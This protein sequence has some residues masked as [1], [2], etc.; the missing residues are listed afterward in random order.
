MS[1]IAQSFKEITDWKESKITEFTE[2]GF[3][4]EYLIGEMEK[5]R[6]RFEQEINAFYA[7]AGGMG[8]IEYDYKQSKI[9]D[10]HRENMSAI[11]IEN[12]EFFDKIEEAY[13]VKL[14]E[15]VDSVGQSLFDTDTDTALSDFLEKSGM[16]SDA[17]YDLTEAAFKSGVTV[18]QLTGYFGQFG[19]SLTEGL[20]AIQGLGEYTSPYEK[21]MDT[22][23]IQDAAKYFETFYASMFTPFE[24][25]LATVDNEAQ[26]LVKSLQGLAAEYPIFADYITD[27]SGFID[28]MADIQ[29][30]QLA[31]DQMSM[32]GQAQAQAMGLDSEYELMRLESTYGVN[33][34]ST[35][36]QQDILS[37]L[38]TASF[39][40]FLQLSTDLNIPMQTLIND[41]LSLA[42]I[43]NET[44]DEF[45]GLADNIRDYTGK[46]SLSGKSYL[47][48]DLK[49]TLARAEF[50]ELAALA[51]STDKETAAAAMAELPAAADTLLDLSRQSNTSMLAYNT[52]MSL[53]LSSLK[54]AEEHAEDY[55][56]TGDDA[57][58]EAEEQTKH[59]K[60]LSHLVGINGSIQDIDS[61]IKN[62]WDHPDVQSFISDFD[63][64]FGPDKLGTLNT[65]VGDLRKTV[66]DY[67][68]SL[69][70]SF[71]KGIELSPSA[72]T[73][74]T[75]GVELSLENNTYNALMAGIG[76]NQESLNALNQLVYIEKYGNEQQPVQIP[77]GSPVNPQPP[78]TPIDIPAP[79]PLAPPAAPALLESEVGPWLR[80]MRDEYGIG[81]LSSTGSDL[82]EL[83]KHFLSNNSFSSDEKTK[84]QFALN[85][86]RSGT[87]ADVYTKQEAIDIVRRL[88]REYF[89]NSSI[90]ESTLD[91][92]A[93]VVYRSWLDNPG[94]LSPQM[95]SILDT[96][97]DILGYASGGDHPGGWRIVGE[98]GPE[99]EYTG[100][101]YI[102]SHSNTAGL[103]SNANKDVVEELR[104][105]R[106]E[107]LEMK[108]EFR[109]L[110][111]KIIKLNIKMNTRQEVW[112]KNGMPEVRA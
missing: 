2:G 65:A 63:K 38:S 35:K 40:D 92:T 26:N 77:G 44:K 105:M 50:Q 28:G 60:N 74:L 58:S 39:D 71:E 10:K 17:F 3:A 110:S 68:L 54:Q 108:K 48:P 79:P 85:Y 94:V 96:T 23:I 33:L 11:S 97:Y 46:L 49:T 1:A 112:D 37:A 7:N 95:M 109:E 78:T 53:V 31:R 93:V 69:E 12:A 101:S 91:R 41:M 82:F 6:A 61:K 36:N 73:L 24:N 70:G 18:E 99:L 52:D 5:E 59:L 88:G 56:G 111:K 106:A 62:L 21:A 14:Q 45:E 89:P 55:A 80:G 72:Q 47:S 98:M 42:N 34:G 57:L 19:V 102:A 30:L 86:L 90:T 8:P 27:I 13:T 87:S 4:T 43:V 20:E 32:L 67:E 66:Q 83:A 51:L 16:S 100:P 64:A 81:L 29:K 84:A 9:Y 25:E 75:E 104:Q 107:N 76:L 22:G 103:L 15:L